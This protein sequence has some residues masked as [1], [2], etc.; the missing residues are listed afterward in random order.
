MV[1]E[2]EHDSSAF[3]VSLGRNKQALCLRALESRIATM[4]VK[5]RRARSRSDGPRR[6]HWTRGRRSTATRV[7]LQDVSAVADSVLR[8]GS[9]ARFGRPATPALTPEQ[10]LAHNRAQWDAYPC[11]RV[12]GAGFETEFHS[13]AAFAGE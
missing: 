2:A 3:C 5:T 4:L 8:I 10:Q 9:Q 1:I 6:P 13:D 11:T 12:Y 7:L